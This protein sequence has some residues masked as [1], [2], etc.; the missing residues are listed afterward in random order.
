M[1]KYQIGVLML[2]I[3]L[4]D[5][6]TAAR[7]TLRCQIEP[8]LKEEE[9]IVYEFSSG[10]SAVRWLR[11][12]AGQI[13]LLFLDIE[14]KESNGMETARLI[15]TF[16]QTLL[17]VFVTGYSDYVFD[18]YGVSA[19]DYVIKPAA[20]ARIQTLLARARNM[21]TAQE[22]Q[23]FTFKNTDGIFRLPLSSIAYFYS[24]RRQVFA[25]TKNGE[26]PFYG[27]LS[28]VSA[29]V[30]SAFVRIHQRY[31]INPSFVDH[32]G[33]DCVT[34]LGQSLPVSRSL[35]EDA[36]RRLANALLS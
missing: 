33:H 34:V 9:E 22:P 32:I 7:D 19:L 20:P 21:L 6:E 2:R 8:F 27:K 3:A 18:G 10:Q 24:D 17:I 23:S 15:R 25:V 1:Y 35:K 29:T 16:D 31:L 11:S 26:F 14:M 5:D 13:D 28:E 36:L 4:C 30:G 12:H